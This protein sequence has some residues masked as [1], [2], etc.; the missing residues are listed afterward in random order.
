M[1]L[2]EEMRKKF[3]YYVHSVNHPLVAAI[4]LYGMRYPEPMRE[5]ENKVDL[6]NALILMDIRD[7]FFKKWDTRGR[8]DFYVAVWRALIVKYV[9]SANYRNFINWVIMMIQKSG[10]KPF[11]PERQMELWKG[12]KS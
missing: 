9:H 10:W 4:T 11:N 1:L 12:G 3:Y 7:E 5:G 6:P 2:R 8:H